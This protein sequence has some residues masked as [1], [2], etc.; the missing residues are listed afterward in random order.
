MTKTEGTIVGGVGV[1]RM[2]KITKGKSAE[3]RECKADIGV[4]ADG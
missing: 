3:L 4:M 2:A 1:S